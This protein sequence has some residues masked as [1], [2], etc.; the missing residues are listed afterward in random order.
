MSD[1]PIGRP[2]RRV[3]C[4]ELR[5]WRRWQASEL[6]TREQP[7]EPPAPVR[8][9]DAE[10]ALARA[11]AHA[12]GHAA[13]L[14]AGREEGLR[15]GR[16]EGHADGLRL[17]HAEGLALA[18]QQMAPHRDA[19]R[20]VLEQAR[21]AIDAMAQDLTPDLVRLALA[22]ARHVVRDTLAAHPA[23]VQDVVR[24]MLSEHAAN[25]PSAHLLVHPD[26]V[27]GLHAALGDALR[28]AGWRLVPD[29]GVTRG[30]CRVHS[31]LGD[32]DAT[33]ETRWRHACDALGMEAA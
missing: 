15:S 33:V 8:D 2:V 21:A 32:I 1:A 12:A 30:G 19:V 31:R 20:E 17:G 26:E 16:A 24:Q 11:D 7:P 6:A 23:I 27:D 9:T 14:A 3:P 18:E 5:D 13:G 28:D 25:T 29:A 22:I 4:R 10:L